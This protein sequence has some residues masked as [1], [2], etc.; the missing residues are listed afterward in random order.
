[1]HPLTQSEG[2]LAPINKEKAPDSDVCFRPARLSESRKVACFLSYLRLFSSHH[3]HLGYILFLP[4]YL[5]SIRR[6]VCALSGD[7]NK[8]L[9]VV[10]IYPNI[11]MGR[12]W[13]HWCSLSSEIWKLRCRQAAQ[14]PCCQG[15]RLAPSGLICQ[16]HDMIKFMNKRRLWA[17]L[18]ILC[19]AMYL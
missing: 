12:S 18:L 9:M 6:L 15:F 2:N 17:A 19:K 11:A 4:F 1:M 3:P 13:V 7:D 5:F 16:L 8:I 10:I 14:Q